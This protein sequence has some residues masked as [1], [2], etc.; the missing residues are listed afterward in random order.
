[1][2]LSELCSILHSIWLAFVA[3][4]I[5]I[6]EFDT[7]A[8]AIE[9]WYMDIQGIWTCEDGIWEPTVPAYLE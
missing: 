7:A 3:G 4:Q 9:G 6:Q 2:D 1:M 8:D 5:S